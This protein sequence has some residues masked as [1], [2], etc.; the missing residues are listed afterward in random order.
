MM[1]LI[2]FLL[3]FTLI[4]AQFA[5]VFH[6]LYQQLNFLLKILALFASRLLFLFKLRL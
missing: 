3:K 2:N 4:I 6:P 1:L 5:Q